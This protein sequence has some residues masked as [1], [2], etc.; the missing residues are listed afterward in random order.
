VATPRILVVD[1][2][3]GRR[4]RAEGATPILMLTALGDVE[5]RV[6]GLDSGADDYRGRILARANAAGGASLYVDLPLLRTSL[7]AGRRARMAFSAP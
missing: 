1:D 4:L 5:E 3:P 6:R 2:G 7:L